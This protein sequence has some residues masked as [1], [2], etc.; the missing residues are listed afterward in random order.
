M[1]TR[2][3]TH[4]RT[5]THT[6]VRMHAHTHARASEHA[7]TH[8]EE[9]RIR[10]DAAVNA[11]LQ[12]REISPE[13]DCSPT[14]RVNEPSCRPPWARRSFGRPPFP[15]ENIFAMISQGKLVQG[16]FQT[17]SMLAD[18]PLGCG[19]PGRPLKA[20]SPKYFSTFKHC[21]EAKTIT[22]STSSSGTRGASIPSMANNSAKTFLDLISTLTAVQT[23]KSFGSPV[24]VA[25]QMVHMYLWKSI[26][27]H[28]VCVC[29]RA[30]ARVCVCVCVC[31]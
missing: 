2:V 3:Y 30:H 19:E 10:F 16:C 14:L 26:S 21:C 22:F 29:A 13:T 20:L 8:K 4:A 25:A 5:H 17:R 6:H 23:P 1:W 27:V 7:R 12:P 28:C 18:T 31:T 9:G 11:T 15:P 24:M